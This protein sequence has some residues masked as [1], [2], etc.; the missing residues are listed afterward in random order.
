[1]RMAEIKKLP[2]EF[3][4]GVVELHALVIDNPC[5]KSSFPEEV[6]RDDFCEGEGINED[7]VYSFDNKIVIGLLHNG[8]QCT[9][10]QSI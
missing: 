4:S 6:L 9:L 3:E 8:F 1:M 2:F 7:R 10:E 5:R